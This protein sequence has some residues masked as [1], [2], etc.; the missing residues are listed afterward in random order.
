MKTNSVTF[1]AGAIVFTFALLFN[2]CDRKEPAAPASNGL[3][4]GSDAPAQSPQTASPFA[5]G[6]S[7]TGGEPQSFLPTGR[8]E[9]D[10]SVAL[11]TTLGSFQGGYSRLSKQDFVSAT[12]ELLGL[13]KKVAQAGKLN[14]FVIAARM[15]D[16]M[17]KELARRTK[18]KTLSHKEA[19]QLF[20]AYLAPVFD[21]SQLAGLMGYP[22]KSTENMTV[23]KLLEFASDQSGGEDRLF[24]DFPENAKETWFL[25]SKKPM[26]KVSLIFG[27]RRNVAALHAY[28]VFCQR[29]GDLARRPLYMHI[30]TV[31]PDVLKQPV[32]VCPGLTYGVLDAGD[33][34]SL[35]DGD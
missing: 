18:Q 10:D 27:A 32:I 13:R 28:F 21:R 16:M 30:Q 7:Q 11:W 20:G 3:T 2:G 17:S 24:D 34:E 31:I 33:I 26:L 25:E 5:T 4:K 12:Q 14:S 1:L 8:L 35:V 15:E 9:I 6:D 23:E 19:E 22:A 29:G